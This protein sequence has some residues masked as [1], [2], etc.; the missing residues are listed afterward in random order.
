MRGAVFEIWDW[1]LI[2]NLWIERNR[3]DAKNTKEENGREEQLLLL[4]VV[5]QFNTSSGF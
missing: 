1:L 2:S 4:F 3:E 5:V